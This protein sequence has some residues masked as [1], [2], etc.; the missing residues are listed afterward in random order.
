MQVIAP[1][2]FFIRDTFQIPDGAVK[3]VDVPEWESV[4]KAKEREIKKITV[5]TPCSSAV[6]FELSG[7]L[8]CPSKSNFNRFGSSRT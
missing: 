3:C 4:Q 5:L 1:H 2:E 6:H 8:S 7:R